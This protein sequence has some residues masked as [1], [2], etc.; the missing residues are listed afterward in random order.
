MLA[1]RI[2]LIK[3]KEIE[4]NNWMFVDHFSNIDRTA[5]ISKQ[6]NYKTALFE[7]TANL[8]TN[9]HSSY[10]DDFWISSIWIW[11]ESVKS[12]SQGD[13]QNTFI[14]NALI[15]TTSVRALDKELVN[16]IM[17]YV[18]KSNSC[19]PLADEA[20]STPLQAKVKRA[21]QSLRVVCT[22]ESQPDS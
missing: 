19:W 1:L 18:F 8:Q 3:L 16:Q 17:A 11:L 12:E 5:V 13:F 7:N 15:S 20:H 10:H 21:N 2:F 4:Q 22:C 14:V 6:W 9:S